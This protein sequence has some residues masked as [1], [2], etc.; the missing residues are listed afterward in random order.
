M[1]MPFDSNTYIIPLKY[2]IFC[3]FCKMFMK[4]ERSS[5]SMEEKLF[6]KHF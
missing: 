5:F 6:N 2:I 4:I 3:F 1:L